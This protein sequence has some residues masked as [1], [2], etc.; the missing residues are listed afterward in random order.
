MLRD[1]ALRQRAAG[2]PAAA[3]AGT[4]RRVLS[5]SSRASLG[6]ARADS[7]H[8][9]FLARKP[10]LHRPT[11]QLG[12]NRLEN[13]ENACDGDQL[14]VELLAEDAR[15]GITM[16]AGHDAPAQRTVDVHTTVRHHLRAGGHSRRDD[17]IAVA[18]VHALPG[19]DWLDLNLRRQ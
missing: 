2:V 13:A 15:G 8:V 11:G 19:A 1:D 10:G 6:R 18:S 3:K 4:R 12:W 7:R 17:E 16:N 9:Q 5:D 14:R